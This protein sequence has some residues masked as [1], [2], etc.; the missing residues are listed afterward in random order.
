MLS[1]KHIIVGITG[2]IAAYKA[3]VLVRLLVRRGAE[4]QVLMTKAAKEFITPLTMATLSKRPI[5]VENFNPENGAWNSHI[6][7]GCWADAMV[8]APATANTLAKM[9][10]GIGDSLLLTTY[11]SA[12][13]PIAVAPAMDLDMMAHPATTQNLQTLEQR[14]VAIIEAE[15]GELASGLSGKGRMAEPECIVEFIEGWIGRAQ[16][17][18]GKRALVTAGA[19]IEAIDPVRYITNHSTGKMGYAIASELAARGAEVKLISGR[20]QLACP[21]GVE[22]ID[23][24][25]ADEMYDACVAEWSRSDIGVMCAAVADYTPAEV[26]ATKI[27]K[28]DDD[29]CIRLRRTRDI[30]AELGANKGERILVGF[31]LE[32]DNE[33]ANAESKLVRK[34]LDFVVMNSMQDKG[35][36]FGGDTNKISIITKEGTESFPLE[37]KTQAAARIADKIENI[38][39]K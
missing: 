20:T 36:C 10:G 35:A 31:A 19:T 37:S 16:T 25:S 7:L 11:L 34:N 17:L 21:K 27:K 22:R 18:A 12:R 38:I 28:S 26:S 24:T 39:T 9:A 3:A 2:G 4:V 30:A 13:C 14:G 32:T 5:L 23:V 15:S 1:G 6:D 29:M 33:Q 8:I